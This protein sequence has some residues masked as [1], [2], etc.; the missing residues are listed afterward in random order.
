MGR[1]GLVLIFYSFLFYVVEGQTGFFHIS[2]LHYDP[3][4]DSMKYNAS[5]FC[6]P[7]TNK[8]FPLESKR[9]QWGS[10]G[11]FGLFGCDS[12]KTLLESMVQSMSEVNNSPAFILLSGDSAA[13]ALLPEEQIDAIRT[14]A[15]V[16][17]KQFPN[18]AI[19]PALGNND[20]EPD[21]NSTCG[22]NSHLSAIA[23]IWKPFLTVDQSRSFEKMGGYN[24]TPISGV[25][26]IV[27]NTVLYS[28]RNSNFVDQS[29]PCGQFAW[30]ISQMNDAFSCG[31]RVIIMGHIPVGIDEYTSGYFWHPQFSDTLRN[32]LNQYQS[33][34]G[35]MLFGHT[36]SD[37]F[38]FFTDPSSTVLSFQ[39]ISPALS[40]IFGN[41]PAF[42]YFYFNNTENFLSSYDQYMLDLFLANKVFV[43]SFAFDF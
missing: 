39:L 9:N 21:Y 4:A 2:D 16:L 40:P 29:D 11:Q 13:H 37:E 28:V 20:F 27:L 5:T 19:Y 31:E 26:L 10:S 42:R 15:E 38:F 30:L 35:A 23:S 33:T 14:V 6:R 17:G 12:P 3:T 24:A 43:S 18:T 8:R 32:L 36:H 41:N 34:I 7:P 1:T 22:P 25:R